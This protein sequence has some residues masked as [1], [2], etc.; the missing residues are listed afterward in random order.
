[1][2]ILRKACRRCTTSKRKC[3]VQLPKCTR[4]AQKGFECK[5]DLDHL[6]APVSSQPSGYDTPGYCVIK[7]IESLTLNVDPAICAPGHED[8]LQTIRLGYHSVPNLVRAGKPAIFVHPDLQL[9]GSYDHFAAFENGSMS[10]E[11]LEHL[12]QIDVKT[13]PVKDALSAHQALLVYLATFLFSSE[14]AEQ[15]SA[16][17]FLGLLS[18]WT[19][20]LLESAKTRMPRNQSPWQDWLFG[21]S[22]RRT[23]IMSHALNFALSSFKYGYCSNWVFLESLPFDRRVGL[24]MARSPQA[25]IAAAR[26]RNGEEVGEQLNSFHEFAAQLDGSD[27]NFQGDTFLHL[28]VFSHNG[29]K[30]HATGPGGN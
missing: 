29:A 4:C 2:A 7:T 30:S 3:V 10:Y 17:S 21:E 16:E 18:E 1:M 6:N 25:W 23:I 8:A 11:K 19:Q 26:V 15:T 9:D 13:L 14:E 20:I 28:L 5:Y 12:T 24:W 27:I 22:V